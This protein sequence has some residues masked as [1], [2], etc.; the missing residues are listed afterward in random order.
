VQCIPD[1]WA[2]AGGV[3]VSYFEWTQNT[4][5]MRWE[6]DEVNQR[7]ERAMVRAHKELR[8][9]MSQHACDM[10]TAA[11]VMAVERVHAAT[12]ARGLG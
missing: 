2:N 7:L 12:T 9:A 3:T 5:H 1:I 6:E 4:Q 8:A 10:R 11:F